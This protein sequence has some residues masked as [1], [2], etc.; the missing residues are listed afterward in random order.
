MDVSWTVQPSASAARIRGSTAVRFR[1]GSAPGSPRQTAHT[2]VLGSAPNAVLQPQ[3]IFDAVRSCAWISRPMTG[4]NSIVGEVEK[5]RIGE[6][7]K[8]RI[9]EVV[10]STT[11]QFANSPIS[12]VRP[13]R[14]HFGGDALLERLEVLHEH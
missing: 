2:C 10:N 3:K 1:T 13:R 9:G 5:W 11:H 4:S 8:G 12:C 7:E 14:E 6:V